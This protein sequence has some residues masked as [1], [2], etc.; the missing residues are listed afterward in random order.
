MQGKNLTLYIGLHAL[1][2]CSLFCLSRTPPSKP[3]TLPFPTQARPT[4]TTGL[5]HLLLPLLGSLFPQLDT[6]L[7]PQV[8]TPVLASQ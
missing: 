8:V 2:S 3:A 6:R 7:T 5:L 4:P 1:E